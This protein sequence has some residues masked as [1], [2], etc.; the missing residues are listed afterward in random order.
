MLTG[1]HVR[2]KKR[3]KEGRPVDSTGVIERRTVGNTFLR[4]FKEEISLLEDPVF[5]QV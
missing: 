5:Y 4:R 1:I 2:V 3:T